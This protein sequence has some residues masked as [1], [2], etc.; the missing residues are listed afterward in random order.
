MDPKYAGMRPV[1][2]HKRRDSLRAGSLRGGR[3][4]KTDRSQLRAAA[5]SNE[6]RKQQVR[7]A[8]D[9]ERKEASP[10]QKPRTKNKRSSVGNI[11][12]G[13]HKV[14]NKTIKRTVSVP[15]FDVLKEEM[16]GRHVNGWQMMTK[17][18]SA[19]REMNAALNKNGDA[20]DAAEQIIKS[21][22]ELLDCDRT[23]L[24]F[25]D[26]E[27]HE[28]ILVLASGAHN[29]RLPIGKGIAGSVAETGATLNIH[30]PYSDD[31]FDPSFDA[32]HGYK[33]NS[34]LCTV[35]RDPEGEPVAVL[36]CINKH[37]DKG[38]SA[39]D[40]MLIKHI[41][42]HAGIVLNNARL[43]ESERSTQEKCSALLEVV[44]TLH[45]SHMTSPHSL[46]FILS[47]QVHRLVDAERCTLY[48]IDQSRN[49]LVVMQGDV[50]IR[51]PMGKGIAGHVATTGKTLMIADAYEDPRFSKETDLKTGFRTKSI[52][53]MPIFSNKV[54]PDS[55]RQE[56]VG[57]LQ[58]INKTDDTE[59]FL[60]S[61]EIL[62]RTLLN[63]AGPLVEECCDKLLGKSQASDFNEGIVKPKSGGNSP[64]NVSPNLSPESKNRR[65]QN[66][67]VEQPKPASLLETPAQVAERFGSMSLGSFE[68]EE[69]E[70]NF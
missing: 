41:A 70:D 21:T 13:A 52:L 25:V 10:A 14:N 20:D 26:E 3:I 47:N 61:D 35:V 8:P 55:G 2:A 50:D 37:S 42:V 6:E 38:F 69:E 49:Q 63:I 16:G 64:S 44:Q 58:V 23:T 34:I 27:A 12:V 59:R 28:I 36:Q 43:L 11:L 19:I 29:I 9:A 56:V 51:V 67:R 7:P 54:E 32:A 15:K 65:L 24:F 39:A 5:H 17:F 18:L 48:L 33:T 4:S 66:T 40:E 45:S 31:R 46:I 60:K 1:Q 57:L 62:L 30:D 68:E 22:C 53:T